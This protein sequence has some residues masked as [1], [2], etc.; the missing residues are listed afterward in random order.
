[1]SPL[2]VPFGFFD[3]EMKRGYAHIRTEDASAFFQL[4][5]KHFFTV[6]L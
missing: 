1:M 6:L 4:T 2:L 5:G 3:K